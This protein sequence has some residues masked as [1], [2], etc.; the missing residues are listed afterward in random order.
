MKQQNL[1]GRTLKEKTKEVVGTC[2]SIGAR[3]EGKSPAEVQ[4]EIDD[5]V[6]D[7]KFA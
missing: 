2:V 1:L 6:Y 3:V 4:K 7:A 5:G